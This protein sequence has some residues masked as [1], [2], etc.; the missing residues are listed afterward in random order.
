M[1]VEELKKSILD[2][3]LRGK[4]VKNDKT[5]PKPK[6]DELKNPIYEIPCNWSWVKINDVINIVRGASPRPIKSFITS[7]TNGVNWIKIGDTE[8]GSKY[9]NSTNEKITLEG[10]EKSRRVNKGDFL[11]SNSMSFGRPY[12]LNIDGC[13]HDGWL[14]LSD[15]N[16]YFNKEYLFYLLSSDFVYKQFCGKASGAVVN[17]LNT[18]KVRDTVIPLPPID[19]QN[20]IVKKIEELFSKLD[21]IKPIEDELNGLKAK[22]PNEM[23]KSILKEF[24]NENTSILMTGN[25][26]LGNLYDICAGEI[27]TGNSISENIK[28]TRYTG[29][30]QGYNYIATKDLQFNH[31][32]NYENGIKI[33]LD[34]EKFKYANKDDILM[35]IEGG[36]AGKKIG[37]LEEKVCYGNK[38]CKF[39]PKLVESKYLYYYL[40][41]PQFL[42]NFN[43]SMT[44]IIGGVS[45]N[46]IK[47]I[48][49]K[50]PP[51]EEQKR[52]VEKLEQLLPLCDDIENLVN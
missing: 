24:Y 46:K 25:W 20:E 27:Y 9:I 12:I 34:E 43:D 40:Q 3:A 2:Y 29:I 35:C 45:I 10:A 17:N 6:I 38:L 22:F 21:D 36:S 5:L 32:F 48:E 33:P 23:R 47:K 30:E 28:K 41:S 13:V 31:T 49:I 11:L 1:I 16:N 4:I 19:E 50:Y 39:S 52:I 26:K 44:G 8:K 51:L 37:I 15:K 18:D 7:D 14:I 42:N